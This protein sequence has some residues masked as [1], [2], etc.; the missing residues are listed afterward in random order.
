MATLIIDKRL[1]TL[2]GLPGYTPR[3]FDLLVAVFTPSPWGSTEI[4]TVSVIGYPI[5]TGLTLGSVT[6]HIALTDVFIIVTLTTI[7]LVN[8][9]NLSLM[10]PH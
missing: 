6:S 7:P 2:Y 9:F 4:V 5:T 1:R 8:Q 3:R 10:M